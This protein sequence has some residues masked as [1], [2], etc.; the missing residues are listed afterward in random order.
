MWLPNISYAKFNSLSVYN[1]NNSYC[2]YVDGSWYMS[3][4]ADLLEAAQDEIFITDWWLSPDIYMKRPD[5]TGKYW[6]Y[7]FKQFPFK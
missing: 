6:K 4:V 2:R 5:L 3:D 7:V 1:E